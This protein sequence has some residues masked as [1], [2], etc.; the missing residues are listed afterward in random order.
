MKMPD[1]ERLFVD[2][3]RVNAETSDQD[4]K[5]DNGYSCPAVDDLKRRLMTGYKEEDYLES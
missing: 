1:I 5:S 2:D 3:V 4:N